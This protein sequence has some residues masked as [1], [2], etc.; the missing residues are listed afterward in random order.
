MQT[1]Q[2]LGLVVAAGL[3]LLPE[4]VTSAT[5]TLVGLG[6]IGSMFGAGGVAP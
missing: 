6:I 4:P 1:W 5:G 3:V 2:L